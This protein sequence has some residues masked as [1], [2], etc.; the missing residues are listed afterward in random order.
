MAV[1]ARFDT[2]T[3][4][5]LVI[6][7]LAATG[8][9]VFAAL[10]GILC[11]VAVS[12]GP[13][14]VF[15]ARASV[16]SED[17]VASSARAAQNLLTKL[18]YGAENPKVVT[19]LSVILAVCAPGFVAVVLTAA[20]G[21]A[22]GVKRVASGFLIFGALASFLVLPAWNAVILLVL[23]VGASALIIAPGVFVARVVLWSVA[24]L[25]AFDHV[26]QLWHGTDA[27]IQK[28]VA[29]LDSLSGFSTPDFW[30]FALIIVGVAPFVCALSAAAY[31][32]KR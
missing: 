6:A 24:T 20:A 4:L 25:I 21:A 13:L 22:R 30:K 26:A 18:P 7:V 14:A 15:K 32:P 17:I 27:E 10:L 9:R 12:T 5:V 28:G 23:A 16:V 19:L 2:G 8:K 3:L 1:P 31:T 29:T 11:G